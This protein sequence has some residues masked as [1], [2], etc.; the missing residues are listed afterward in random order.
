MNCQLISDKEKFNSF[1]SQCFAKI[2]GG[3]GVVFKLARVFT[4]RVDFGNFYVFINLG[5]V[6]ALIVD[7]G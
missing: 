1:F 7:Y 3:I 4:F 5:T 2:V 6:F